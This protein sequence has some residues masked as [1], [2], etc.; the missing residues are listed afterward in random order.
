V[1]VTTEGEKVIDLLWDVIAAKGFEADTYFDK[2]PRT[3]AA[4]R[5]SRA[6]CTSTSR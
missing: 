1:K 4:Y 3:S 5:S 2:A 6:P